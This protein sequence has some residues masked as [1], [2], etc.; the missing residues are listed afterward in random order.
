LIVISRSADLFFAWRKAGR[1]RFR[2]SL[3]GPIELDASRWTS[4]LL[5][6]ASYMAAHLSRKARVATCVCLPGEGASLVAF[7]APEVAGM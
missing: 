6:I 7:Y 4:V 5:L 2:V 3:A 1:T